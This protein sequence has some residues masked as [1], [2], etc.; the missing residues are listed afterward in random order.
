MA[1]CVCDVL[2]SSWRV[3]FYSILCILGVA[4]AVAGAGAG[5]EREREEKRA[6]SVYFSIY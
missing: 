3:V 2:T 1:L 6:R 5:R 4:V